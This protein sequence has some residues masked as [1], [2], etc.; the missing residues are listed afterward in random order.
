MLADRLRL[1]QQYARRA[2]QAPFSTAALGRAAFGARPPPS[3]ADPLP[4]LNVKNC[5]SSQAQQLSV[6]DR[7]GDLWD[8]GNVLGNTGTIARGSDLPTPYS[9]HVPFTY[10]IAHRSGGFAVAALH[11][12]VPVELDLL[13]GKDLHSVALLA[14]RCCSSVSLL[15]SSFASSGSRVQRLC[16]AGVA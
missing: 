5:R 9:H 2:R 3:I 8:W 1:Q 6:G 16:G 4:R 14:L 10:S 12:S 11:P 7:A 13:V 15:T